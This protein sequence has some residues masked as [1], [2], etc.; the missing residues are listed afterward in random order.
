MKVTAGYANGCEMLFLR[1]RMRALRPQ[2]VVCGP[3]L[4]ALYCLMLLKTFPE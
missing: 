1:F 3:W 4:T 2:A